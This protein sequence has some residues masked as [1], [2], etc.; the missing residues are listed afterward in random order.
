MSYFFWIE[1]KNYSGFKKKDFISFLQS[2]SANDTQCSYIYIDGKREVDKIIKYENLIPELKAIE[3]LKH[4]NFDS[5]PWLNKSQNN[6]RKYCD[7]ELQNLI[8]SKYKKDFD[9][10]GYDYEI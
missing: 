6:Y 2:P 1:G 9:I 10:F 4:K 5:F 8:Y 3:C 7:K